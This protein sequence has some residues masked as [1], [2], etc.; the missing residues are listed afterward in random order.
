MRALR[1]TS[2]KQCFAGVTFVLA[3]LM[4]VSSFNSAWDAAV[5]AADATAGSHMMLRCGR[6]LSA[7]DELEAVATAVRDR[8]TAAAGFAGVCGFPVRG[9]TIRALIALGV[10]NLGSFLY[11]RLK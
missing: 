1:H 4:R 5:Y 10:G 2:P 11:S 6:S 7:S 8:M 9:G 3:I